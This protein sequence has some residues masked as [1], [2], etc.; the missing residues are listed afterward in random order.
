MVFRAHECGELMSH[1][2][3]ILSLQSYILAHYAMY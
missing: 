3:F 1:G 2:I